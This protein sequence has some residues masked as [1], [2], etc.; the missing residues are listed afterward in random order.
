MSV[1]ILLITVLTFSAC[2]HK[3]KEIERPEPEEIVQKYIFERLIEGKCSEC[4]ERLM[5]RK[6]FLQGGRSRYLFEE[7]YPGCTGVMESQGFYS[8][9]CD[10]GSW[11]EKVLFSMEEQRLGDKVLSLL[12]DESFVQPPVLND[13]EEK[14]VDEE[15]VE[16]RLLDA[17]NRLKSM[18][19]G[20]EYFIPVR[21]D[22]ESVFVHYSN[23]KAVRFFYDEQFRLVKKELWHMVS[24]EDSGLTGTERYEYKDSSIYPFRKIIENENSGIVS[25]LNENGLVIRAEKYVYE[26]QEDKDE[27]KKKTVSIISYEYDQKDRLVTE[28]TI[29]FIYD[30]AKLKKRLGKKQVFIYHPDKPDGEDSDIPPD[31]RY[32]E[33]NVL[34]TSTE[35]TEKD[36]YSTLIIFD[37]TNSVRTYYENYVKVKDVYLS[38]GQEKRVKVY[39]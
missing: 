11:V 29:D 5:F 38:G 32:Y 14:D 30:G 22:T 8:G 36:K 33:D 27:P 31:Y 25:N 20:S 9:E 28:Q 16:K 2:S 24:V 7:L 37:E 1:F 39:E 15:P 13:T 17:N 23:N 3:K 12:E 18:K 35:Y 6:V 21:K 10:N 4:F 26:K 34:R 19:F